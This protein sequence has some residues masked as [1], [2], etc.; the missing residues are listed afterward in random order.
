MN[1]MSVP[2]YANVSFELGQAMGCM[3][4]NRDTKYEEARECLCKAIEWL[5]EGQKERKDNLL[6]E[7]ELCLS[8]AH[9]ALKENGPMW[10]TEAEDNMMKCMKLLEDYYE[11]MRS[12]EES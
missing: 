6:Y 8:F 3:D 11:R 1:V 12:N 7:M 9:T 5:K 4:S 10:I 2:V